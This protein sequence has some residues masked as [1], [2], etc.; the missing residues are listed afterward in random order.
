MT[1]IQR[2]RVAWTG[3]PGAPGVSTFYATTAATPMANIRTFFNNIHPFL[4]SDVT[5]SFPGAGDVL[6]DVTGILTGS[7]SA[8]PP[9]DVTGSGTGTYA[10]PVGAVVNWGTATIHRGRR[11]RGR[12]FLVPLNGPSFQNDGSLDSTVRAG[13]ISGAQALI[14]AGPGNLLAWSR[15]ISG[16]GGLSAA[17]TTANVPDLAAVLRSRR[18]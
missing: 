8:A 15:P 13:L 5:L 1:D 14:A 12:T 11:M 17:V 4:P 10:A 18:D 16:G 3:F 7:W 6:D 9:A 2:I